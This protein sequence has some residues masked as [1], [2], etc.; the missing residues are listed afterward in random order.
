MSKLKSILIILFKI[1]GIVKKLVI[2]GQIVNSAYYCDVLGRLRE[3]VQ[4]LRPKL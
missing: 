3:N 2:A 4:R 1:K